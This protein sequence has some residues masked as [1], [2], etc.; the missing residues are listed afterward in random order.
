METGTN[1]N[2]QLNF[3][4]GTLNGFGNLTSLTLGH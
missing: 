3:N 4:S 1:H 2:S